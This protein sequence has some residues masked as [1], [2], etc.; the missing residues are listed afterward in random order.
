MVLI[1]VVSFTVLAT[2]ALQSE[3]RKG[4]EG[5]IFVRMVASEFPC[6]VEDK[7]GSRVIGCASRLPSALRS[8]VREITSAIS[9]VRSARCLGAR[10]N[11][12]KDVFVTSQ[13]WAKWE[14][15]QRSEN[16]L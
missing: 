6:V 7:Q 11:D 2:K 8:L 9:N 5:A 10:W 16:Q 4:R 12:I 13:N 15:I 3:I 1:V 14:G